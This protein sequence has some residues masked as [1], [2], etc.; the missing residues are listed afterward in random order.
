MSTDV[1]RTSSRSDAN[2]DCVAVRVMK[3]HDAE[4]GDE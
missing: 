1:W 3:R 2:G 4:D